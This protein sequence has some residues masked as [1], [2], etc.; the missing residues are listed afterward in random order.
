MRYTNIKRARTFYEFFAGGGMARAGLGKEWLC[1]FAN[2]ICS[3]K[4]ETYRTNWGNDELVIRDVASLTS[5]DL[6]READLA[7]ASF[8][9]QDLSL[10]GAGA[11]LGGERSGTFWHFWNLVKQL[12]AE[13]RKPKSIVLENVYGAIT[14]HDGKDFEAIVSALA[15]E[16]YNVGAMVIDAVHFVPQ[17][18]PRLF[19]IAADDRINLPAQ[20]ISDVP[21]PGWHP[22]TLIGAYNSLS[23]KIQKK[24]IWWNLPVPTQ[25]L[26]TL[27]EIIEREPVG[28]T[29]HASNETQKL[30]G[31]MT[32]INRR[33]VLGAQADKR[34]RVGTIYKRTRNGVQRAEVRFDGISGCLRTP[35]GGSSRQTIILV[36]GP[37]I[38]TRLLSPREAARLMGLPDSYKLPSKYN[39][40][41]HVAGDGV[42]V[43]VVRHLA[44]YILEPL[45]DMSQHTQLKQ[46]A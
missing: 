30:L 2:D 23:P 6:P 7:W 28:V 25:H 34:V 11:G 27:D 46:R 40:A 36:D 19:I 44:R 33:K 4:A 17:S 22:R 12:A 35:A 42:A 29:W 10:A 18:R 1:L 5:D 31:M 8:P 26:K 41:Y 43:P 45:I 15:S 14:S 3:K 38:S 20:L 21:K 13:G 16:N 39:D 32:S 9:C 24:W 37:K